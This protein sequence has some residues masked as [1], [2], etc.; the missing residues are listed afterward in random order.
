[1]IKTI[2]KFQFDDGDKACG[3]DLITP[4]NFNLVTDWGARE[5]SGDSYYV[6]KAIE[7]GAKSKPKKQTKK[8]TKKGL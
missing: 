2:I 3:A 5:V 4:Q 7:Q 8:K 1:M 6:D